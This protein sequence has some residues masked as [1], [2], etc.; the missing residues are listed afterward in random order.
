[1]FIRANWRCEVRLHENCSGDRELPWDGDVFTRGHLVHIK[2]RGAG[3]SWD[4]SNLLLGCPNC[5]LISMHTE[6]KRPA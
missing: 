3:G 1:V 6:G 2:S 5:H 4:M